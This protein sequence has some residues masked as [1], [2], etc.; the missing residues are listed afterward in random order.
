MRDAGPE[1]MKRMSSSDRVE[2]EH[3]ANHLCVEIIAILTGIFVPKT[4]SESLGPGRGILSTSKFGQLQLEPVL[5][6]GTKAGLAVVLGNR[7]H[8]SVSFWYSFVCHILCVLCLWRDPLRVWCNGKRMAGASIPADTNSTYTRLGEQ[9]GGV[10]L[11][12]ERVLQVS[13]C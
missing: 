6:M 12:D 4:L 11:C 10:V 3:S 7:S 2:N 13:S 8:D 5:M 9:E 1:R